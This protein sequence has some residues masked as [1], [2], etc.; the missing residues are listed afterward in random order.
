V[1]EDEFD[2]T[3]QDQ[4]SFNIGESSYTSVIEQA[5]DQ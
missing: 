2:G 3:V 1:F 4:I 5:L